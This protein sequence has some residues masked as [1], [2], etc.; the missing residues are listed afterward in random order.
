M[1][2]FQPLPG[3][4]PITLQGGGD[5]IVPG[6]QQIHFAR[7]NPGSPGFHASEIMQKAQVYFQA[8]TGKWYVISKPTLQAQSYP[9]FTD[10]GLVQA[11]RL[12]DVALA[13]GQL[14][15]DGY[16]TVANQ[17][18]HHIAVTI[19]KSAWQSLFAADAQN[20]SAY[21]SMKNKVSQLSGNIEFWID[22][23]TFYIHSFL[24]TFGYD[25]TCYNNDGTLL[26]TYHLDQRLTMD[27]SKF[28]QPITITPPTQATPIDSLDML[29][30]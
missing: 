21:Q 7:M 13:H 10:T 14:I 22:E 16:D 9:M 24:L 2:A 29:V 5:E 27:F 8:L 6:Q 28:N 19:D 26:G 25:A 11:N 17:K 30:M 1:Q 23:S 20:M 12:L 4:E 3:G 18:L 15:D